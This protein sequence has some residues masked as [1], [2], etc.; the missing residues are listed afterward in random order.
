[1]ARI[2]VINANP[3]KDSFGVALSAAYAEGAREAGAQ[4]EVIDLVDLDFDP[5]LR[6][7]FG[8]EQALEPD[9][10]RAQRAIE[11]AD[12]VVVEFPVWWGS[13]PALLRGF[14]DRTFLPGWAFRNTGGALPEGL[15]AGR[16]AR[17]VS[18]MDSPSWWYWFKHGRAAHRS[19]VDATLNYVGIKKVSETTIYALRTLEAPAR[20]SWLE[21]VG[22]LGAADARRTAGASARALAA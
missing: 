12:H 18:T 10:E 15:L 7:G 13:M 6:A 5:I 2:L 21:K 14:V 11:R 8:G 4:V 9:L 1:M 22:A 17:L 20:Q 3:N 16:T 19:L